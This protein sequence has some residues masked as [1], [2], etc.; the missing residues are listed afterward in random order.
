M[1]NRELGMEEVHKRLR[2]LYNAPYDLKLVLRV[3]SRAVDEND[4]PCVLIMEGDDQITKRSGRDYLGYGCLRTLD[5]IVECWDFVESGDV[6]NI[7]ESV[8]TLVLANRGVLLQGVM[9]REDRAVGP[10]NIGIPN[11]LGM[12]AI[13]SLTYKDDGPTFP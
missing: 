12:K 3:P 10:Y 5:V 4:M 6:R 11:I 9:I 2:P 8:R 1:I 13:F 7:F